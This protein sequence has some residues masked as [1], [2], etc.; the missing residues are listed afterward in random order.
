MQYSSMVDEMM[1]LFRIF[2]A[3]LVNLLGRVFLN[4]KSQDSNNKGTVQYR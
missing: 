2:V 1:L 3:S 4:N